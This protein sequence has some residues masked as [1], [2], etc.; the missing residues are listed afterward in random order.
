MSRGFC[1]LPR[2]F[3]RRAAQPR[4]L[5]RRL[6]RTVEVFCWILGFAGISWLAVTAIRIYSFQKTQETQ[7]DEKIERPSEPNPRTKPKAPEVLPTPSPGEAIGKLSIPRIGL[8]A[9]VAEGVDESTLRKAVGHIPGTAIPE[10]TGNVALA[11]HRDTFFREL[12]NVRVDDV[13]VMET[14][15]GQYRYRV[16]RTEVVGPKDTEVL[17]SGNQPELT[18]ITCYPFHYVGPAPERFIVEASR[19]PQS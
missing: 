18:L 15:R 13:I 9:I 10:Q 19:L 12:G 11:G 17:Q 14:P 4:R 2:A 8:S 7:F 16:E 6:L 3:P 1:E 5:F